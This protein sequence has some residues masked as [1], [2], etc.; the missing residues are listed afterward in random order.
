MIEN[1][2]L[3]QNLPRLKNASVLVVGDVMLDRFVYGAVERISPE[4][5]IPVL[6]VEREKQMLG[7]SGNVAANIAALGAVASIVCVVGKDAAG[8]EVRLQLQEAGIE[9]LLVSSPSAMT[10][11]K[12]RF[13][14]STQQVLRVDRE[15]TA[16][17]TAELEDQVVAQ[18]IAKI[19]TVGAVVLSDYGK[20]VL[21]ARVVAQI[22]TAA[23]HANVPVIVD[24]K[25][26]DFSKYRG[27]TAVTPNRKELEA[28]TSMKAATNDDVRAAAMKIIIECGIPNVL[29][30]RSKDG[31]SLISADA[32][33]LHIAAQVREVFDVSG[34]GDT[35]IAAFASLIASGIDMVDAAILA[36]VAAGIAVGK[37][38]T[39]VVFPEEIARV[40]TYRNGYAE[41]Q[42]QT[43]IASLKTAA[44]EA[45]RQR[46]HGKKVGF[47]NG[48][49]DLLHPGHLATL[50]QARAAC[51]FLVV[52][53]NSDASVKRLKGPS[54]P[55]QDE[56]ARAAVLAAMN[57]VDMVVVFGEDT[58]IEL[59]TAIRP[60]VLVKGGQYKLEEVVGYDIVMSYGGKIV[61]ADMED[62]FSTTNTIARMAS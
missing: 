20:G 5:P 52:A 46:A 30:T 37:A 38:G 47:T 28:A 8:E 13:I 11:V 48:C 61:R 26:V 23:K 33:P 10:T 32:E 51:D 31:M 14:G 3:L 49:F 2:Q 27:A 9:G 55:I 7:G 53:I 59:I 58:P 16:A 6:L 39:A 1:K 36:N 12:S 60:D 29:A 54:R 24:P 43:K 4:A 41:T 22:I 17:I 25:G 21:S 15:N 34:A 19:A 56:T 35:V 40:I 57:M 45:N 62:G 18:V 42:E 50:R 44:V